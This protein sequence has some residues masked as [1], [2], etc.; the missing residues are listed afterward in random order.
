M[1]SAPSPAVFVGAPE[2]ATSQ[3][4]PAGVLVSWV[5]QLLSRLVPPHTDC[6]LKVSM[7]LGARVYDRGAGKLADAL[8][9]LDSAVNEIDYDIVLEPDRDS[10][11]FRGAWK[12]SARNA[13]KIGE[14]AGEVTAWLEANDPGV[15]RGIVELRMEQQ[16]LREVLV[17]ADLWLGEM[18]AD[19]RQRRPLEGDSAGLEKLRSLAA[20]AD[21][22]GARVRGLQAAGRAVEEGCVLAENVL[23]LRRALVQE[24]VEV[25]QPRHAA[26]EQAVVR[27][28]EAADSVNWA[29]DIGPAQDEDAHLRSDIQRCMAGCDKLRHEEHA[30]QRCLVTTCEQLRAAL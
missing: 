13:R 14:L 24:L 17:H 19:L 6:L 18:W 30:L 1:A 20:K 15:R 9:L 8:R 4:Q 5:E 26:W 12:S 11:A 27:V 10:S 2:P 22:L 3:R 16:R 28:V 29:G 7:D 21:A 25:L 23:A